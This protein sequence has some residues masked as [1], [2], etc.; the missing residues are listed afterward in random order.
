LGPDLTWSRRLEEYRR[1]AA[2]RAF[3]VLGWLQVRQPTN[4]LVTCTIGRAEILYGFAAAAGLRERR[5]SETAR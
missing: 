1:N 3:Y 4:Q 2:I 5:R